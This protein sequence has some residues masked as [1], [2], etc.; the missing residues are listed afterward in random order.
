MKKRIIPSILLKGGT[1]VCL[2]QCFEPWRTVG[3]LV[4]NLRLHINRE[5]DELLIINSD[6]SYKKEFNLSP[7]VLDLIRKE[8]DIPIGYLGGIS[9]RESASFCINAGFDKIYITSAFL[10]NTYSAREISSLIGSQSLGI[11]LPYGYKKGVNKPL[12]YNYKDKKLTDIELGYMI[13]KAEKFGAG[14]IILFNTIRDGSMLGLDINI[15]NLLKD[16][17]PG[18][19][20]L[21]A[22]G[23]G[24]ESD[25]SE[26]LL[27]DNV[28]GVI[29]SSIFALTSATPSTI[30]KHCK[31]K[32][33]EMRRV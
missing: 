17:N 13:K 29:A 23:A 2:S 11:C 22:G 4:Q 26:V 16:L 8:V 1:N 7:R 25:I 10:E 5:A 33:I 15:I 12:I 14:E 24:K 6:F 28:Q 18:I 32:G 21:L 9:N 19:P 20:L 3:T 31:E 30:R 27:S